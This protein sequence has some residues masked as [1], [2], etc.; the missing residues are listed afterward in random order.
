MCL[1]TILMLFSN[2][3]I[4]VYAIC[5]INAKWETIINYTII[6]LNPV[7]ADGKINNTCYEC[8]FLRETRQKI[9]DGEKL[10]T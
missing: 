2:R 10:D 7:V 6:R 3:S 1:I 5:E 9:L 8:V 4:F